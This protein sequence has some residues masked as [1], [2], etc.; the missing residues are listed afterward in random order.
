MS[1]PYCDVK[2]PTDYPLLFA[3]TLAAGA[4]VFA[5][6]EAVKVVLQGSGSSGSRTTPAGAAQGPGL[7]AAHGLDCGGD[8]RFGHHDSNSGSRM[9]EENSSSSGSDDFDDLSSSLVLARLW[10]AQCRHGPDVSMSEVTARHAEDDFVHARQVNPL[11]AT[12]TSLQ[13]NNIPLM[14]MQP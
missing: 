12:I 5:P 10:W 8:G 7:D 6:A 2:I 14:M 13:A 9:C 11:T 4:S 3:T 1:F